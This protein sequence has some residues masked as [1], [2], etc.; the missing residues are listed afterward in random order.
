MERRQLPP[1]L[2]PLPRREDHR[3]D[4]PLRQV[5]PTPVE[6]QTEMTRLELAKQDPMGA[7]EP[8]LDSDQ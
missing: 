8:L 5:A 7:G 1:S 3:T 4:R 6:D 2:V